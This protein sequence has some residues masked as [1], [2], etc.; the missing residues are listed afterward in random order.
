MAATCV[1]GGIY[2]RDGTCF[3]ALFFGGTICIE[4][5]LLHPKSNE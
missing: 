3:G 2:F 4:Q 1:G 5:I